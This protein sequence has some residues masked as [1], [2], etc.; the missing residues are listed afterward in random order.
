MSQQQEAQVA[1][2]RS[3]EKQIWNAHKWFVPVVLIINAKLIASKEKDFYLILLLLH[4]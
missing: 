4:M 1:F 3:P 2:S